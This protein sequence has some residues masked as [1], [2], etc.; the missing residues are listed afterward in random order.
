LQLF[1]VDSQSDEEVEEVIKES[2]VND[3]YLPVLDVL[4]FW[5]IG[6]NRLSKPVKLC[7]FQDRQDV[8]PTIINVILFYLLYYQV[9]WKLW[10]DSGG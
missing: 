10:A 8:Y 3:E 7:N 1:V 2:D 6:K 5:R 4:K 9:F